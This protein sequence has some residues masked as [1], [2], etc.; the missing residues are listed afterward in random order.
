M[1]RKN[2]RKPKHPNRLWQEV[3]ESVARSVNEQPPI[4][5]PMNGNPSG[6]LPKLQP[7]MQ[8]PL[9]RSA[10]SGE[11]ISFAPDDPEPRSREGHRIFG[12]PPSAH[13]P[14][15]ITQRLERVRCDHRI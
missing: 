4:E 12:G 13:H 15:D 1:E 2:G 5:V 6:L 14:D 8:A 10:L 3:P 11:P 7:D 9:V